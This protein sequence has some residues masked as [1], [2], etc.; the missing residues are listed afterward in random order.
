VAAHVVEAAEFAIFV[1][2]DED[3]FAG[4]V[5][6]DEVAGVR[7]LL[8]PAD[9]DPVAPPDPLALQVIDFETPVIVAA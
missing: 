8:G 2:G 3:G 9:G 5:F 6:R 1:P 4:D 7:D